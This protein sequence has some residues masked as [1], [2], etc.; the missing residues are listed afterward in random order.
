D[1]DGLLDGRQHNTYDIEFYGPNPLCGIHY[2]AGLRA[3]EELAKVMGEPELAARCRAEFERGSARLD[4]V[5]WNGEYYVQRLDDINEHKYQ[6]ATG[7]LSDQL[8]AQLHARM[9]GLGDL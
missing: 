9:L 8:L 1:N 6:H 5:L 7:C 3:V 2:L 4:E